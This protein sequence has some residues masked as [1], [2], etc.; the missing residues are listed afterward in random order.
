MDKLDA[1]TP[2]YQPGFIDRL[3]VSFF[4]FVNKYIPW[5]KLPS[6]IG[7]LNLE[8]LRVELRQKNLW[9]GYATAAPQGT[10][11]T[12]PL[13]DKRYLNARHSDGKFNS[14]EMPNM[15]CAG[16][17]FGRN[18]PR[19]YTP[20]PTEA[21]LWNPNPRVLSDLFMK[22]KEFIP[23]TTLNLLAAA[24]IQFQTHDWF[25]HDTDN[26]GYDVPLPPGDTWPH[27]KMTILHSKPDDVLH[28][29]DKVCPGYKNTETAWWD[30]S[31]IYGDN[32]E[33]TKLLRDQS[34]DGKLAMVNGKFI[35]RDQSGNVK[36]GFNDNWWLGL[37]LLHTLFVLEHNSICDM[38]H[39]T[40]PEMPW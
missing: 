24:W 17:R 4:K 37:E 34:T 33:A 38:L 11:L 3:N 28:P 9:D 8:A 13:T 2:S 5:H 25:H 12:E 15:G 10:A 14:L 7:A 22:R 6:L 21:E 32:E 39:N 26:N 35:P 36:T 30:G 16:M 27:G 20:K 29:S 18:F 1:Q 19:Q 31:Q 23:A 40:H